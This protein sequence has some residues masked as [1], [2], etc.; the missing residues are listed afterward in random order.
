MYYTYAAYF[1]LAGPPRWFAGKPGEA[2]KRLLARSRIPVARKQ[3]H[4]QSEPSSLDDVFRANP[5]TFIMGRCRHYEAENLI[6]VDV[7]SD[8]YCGTIG[9]NIQYSESSPLRSCGEA[10]LAAFNALLKS[11]FPGRGI[12]LIDKGFGFRVPGISPAKLRAFLAKPC[13]GLFQIL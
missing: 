9:V 11:E 5:R 1:P 4:G 3:A 12:W 13:E 2:H 7:S 10:R 6:L 8:Y